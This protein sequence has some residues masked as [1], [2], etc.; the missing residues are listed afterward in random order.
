MIGSNDRNY[1]LSSARQLEM[2]WLHI[3][4]RQRSQIFLPNAHALCQQGSSCGP[5]KTVLC[6][7]RELVCVL[8]LLLFYTHTAMQHTLMLQLS[9]HNMQPGQITCYVLFHIFLV[10]N[11]NYIFNIIICVI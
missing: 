11:I 1:A 9:T 6:N 8:I 10:V 3:E 4:N 5:H 7:N 2:F